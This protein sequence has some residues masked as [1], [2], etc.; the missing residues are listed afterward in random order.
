VEAHRGEIKA[1]SSFGFGTSFIAI[2]PSNYS[3][4]FDEIILGNESLTF[5]T[6]LLS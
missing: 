3:P 4:E 5:G 1:Y 6:R 2:I